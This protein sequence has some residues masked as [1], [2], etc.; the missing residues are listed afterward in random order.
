MGRFMGLRALRSSMGA[1]N[2]QKILSH[3]PRI[4]AGVLVF[5]ADEELCGIVPM[6]LLMEVAGNRDEDMQAHAGTKDASSPGVVQ[7]CGVG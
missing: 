5:V 2:G 7:T 3:L 4:N 1:S 6:P